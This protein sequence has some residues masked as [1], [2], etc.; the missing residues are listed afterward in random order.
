MTDIGRSIGAPLLPVLS[1]I[2]A[3]F[4]AALSVRRARAK[5]RDP[6]N[7]PV[8]IMLCRRCGG[9][10]AS[11]NPSNV[12]ARAPSAPLEHERFVEPA[13]PSSTRWIVRD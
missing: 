8:R 4:I 10:V 1:V 2:V 12:H 3:T 6:A 7:L 11:R 5:K 13:A 9:A